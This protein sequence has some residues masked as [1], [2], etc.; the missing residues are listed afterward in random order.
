MAVT[1]ADLPGLRTAG[2]LGE[3]P[4]VYRVHRRQLGGGFGDQAKHPFAWGVIVYVDGYL[5]RINSARGSGREWSSFERLE[6]WMREQGF[7]YW[8][9]RNDLEPLGDATTDVHG[10]EVLPTESLPPIDP[11]SFA[12]VAPVGQRDADM[13]FPPTGKDLA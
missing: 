8:W 6:K 3:Y 7:W 10:E 5:A 4:V 9:M 11:T 12:E 13:E 1:Q 2:R